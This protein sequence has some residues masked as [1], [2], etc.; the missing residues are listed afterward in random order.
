MKEQLDARLK[1]I[2]ID[3]DS[4]FGCLMKRTAQHLALN[5][6][7]YDSLDSLGFI[8]SLALYDIIIVDHQMSNI[9][10]IEVASYIPSLFSNKT[11]ILISST[12]LKQDHSVKI[13]EFITEFI[14]KDASCDRVLQKAI[15]AHQFRLRSPYESSCA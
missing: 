1:I 10:G 5:L 14:H 7:F 2:L 11:V 13:P 9:S 8:G 12:D 3:D 4:A 6:D 15:A